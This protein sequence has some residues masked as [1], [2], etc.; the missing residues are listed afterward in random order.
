PD[1]H[2]IIMKKIALTMLSFSLFLSIGISVNLEEASAQNTSIPYD[3]QAIK[4]GIGDSLSKLTGTNSSNLLSKTLVLINETASRLANDT[5]DT[6]NGG[7]LQQA[8][9]I[10]K[11]IAIGIADV[12]SNISGEAKQGLEIK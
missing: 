3:M 1:H 4:N 2:Q 5:T 11:K 6:T 7:S 9:I 12:L 10:G 8:E